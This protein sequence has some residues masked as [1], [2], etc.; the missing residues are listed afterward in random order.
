MSLF[1]PESTEF[2]YHFTYK[3]TVFLIE[4]TERKS[5]AK[6]DFATSQPAEANLSQP[7][8]PLGKG[9]K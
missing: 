6:I 7:K 8:P 9:R 4:S 5:T 3:S 1:L 2:L